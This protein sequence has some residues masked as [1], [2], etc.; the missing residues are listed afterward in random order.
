MDIQPDEYVILH[1]VSPPFLR[2]GTNQSGYAQKL[3]T[4]DQAA[5]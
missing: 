3:V 1:L 2:L 4:L 5:V